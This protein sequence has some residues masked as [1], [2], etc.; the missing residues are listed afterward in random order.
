MDA[1]HGKSYGSSVRQS[2]EIS[3]EDVASSLEFE[4]VL[5]ALL[6]RVCE[7]EW[8]GLMQA[9]RTIRWV[10]TRLSWLETRAGRSALSQ[11]GLNF[12]AT[13]EVLSQKPCILFQDTPTVG[14][15]HGANKWM[16]TYR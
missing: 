5:Q 8:C 4:S 1:E 2:E 15:E 3:H 12:D 16:V 9:E 13:E 6:G 10:D 7:G 11:M 14:C